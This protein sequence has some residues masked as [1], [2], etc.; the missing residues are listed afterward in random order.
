MLSVTD[1]SRSKFVIESWIS[2][3]IFYLNFIEGKL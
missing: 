1:E 2:L 3:F